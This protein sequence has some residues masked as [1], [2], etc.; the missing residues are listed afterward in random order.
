MH[1]PTDRIIQDYTSSGAL[2]GTRNSSMGPPH[3][4]SI[5]RP[6]A[7]WANALTTVLHLAPQLNI[8]AVGAEFVSRSSS[9]GYISVTIWSSEKW[10]TLANWQGTTSDRPHVRLALYATGQCFCTKSTELSYFV[11]DN[12][13]YHN[14][15]YKIII[16]SSSGMNERMFN[17]TPAQKTHSGHWVSEKGKCTKWLSN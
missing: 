13:T 17:D 15:T 6:I 4:G 11:Y 8:E 14:E 16:V 10:V 9:D 7:P 2:A 5:R 12:Q 3:E 1:H